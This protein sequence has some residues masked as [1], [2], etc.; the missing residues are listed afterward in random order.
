MRK[1]QQLLNYLEKHEE[2]VLTYN[3]SNMIL[4]IHSDTSY[5]SEPKE[6]IQSGG[7]FFLSR[8]TTIKA[9]NN[10]ILNIAHII[11]HVITS[12]TEA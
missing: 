4:D 2:A 10:V 7:H 11:K 6:Q 12:E 8:N 9:N 5:L 1:T 3:S